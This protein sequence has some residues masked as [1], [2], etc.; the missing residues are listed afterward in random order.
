MFLSL[1]WKSLYSRKGSVLLTVLALT[2]SIIVLLGVEHIR[3]QSKESFRQTVSG[4]D[5]IVGARTSS[6]NLLLYSVFRMGNATNNI[7]W[8]TYQKITELPDIAWTIPISLGDSHKGYR[9]MGTTT[10]Y[11]TH[12]RYGQQQSLSFSAGDGFSDLFDVVLGADVARKLNYQL[13]D[14]LILSHGL[15]STQF[16]SH[17]DKPFTVVGIL[18][19]TGT[20]VD[21]ALHVSL[22]GIEAIHINWQQ[23]VKLPVTASPAPLIDPNQL[24]PQSITAMMVGLNSKIS[25]FRVQRAINQYRGEALTAILPGVALSELWQMMA[26]MENT[27]RLISVLILVASLLGLSAMMLASIRERQREIQV[28][29]LIGASP[30]F[31]FRLIQ[32]EA[33]IIVLLS[34]ALAG[35]VLSA[36]LLVLNGYLSTEYGLHISANFISQSSLSMMAA[37]IAATVLV[38]TIPAVSAYHR[39]IKS[40]GQ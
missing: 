32:V 12:F 18:A 15:V 22:A 24:L 35:G 31:L 11:F 2:V 29:R 37:V 7:G 6:T 4:V 21:Q 13:G 39:G 9:V 1:C 23:G 8:S 34:M 16:S 14:S 33:L 28:M 3:Q 25:T 40:A 26:V 10:D 36:S 17:D 38:S 19:P 27:L 20:P 5:L 30:W